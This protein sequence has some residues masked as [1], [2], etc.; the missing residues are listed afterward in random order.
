MVYNYHTHTHRCGH[1]DG[2]E[3]DYIKT[4][5][6]GGIK[7]MGFS[8]HIPLKFKDGTESAYRVPTSEGKEYCD[9]IKAFREKYKGKIDI[10]VGFE[11]EY[12]PELFDE[13]LQSA[14]EYGAEYLI[15]GQHFLAPE[16]T[17]VSANV[18]MTEDVGALKKYVSYVISAMDKNVF[19]YIAHPDFFNFG[20]DVGIYQE[21]M[22]KLCIAA[23][24]RNV[25]LEMNFLGIRDNRHYPNPYF[26]QVAGE[27]KSPVIFGLDAHT[28]ESAFDGDSLVKAKEMV[29]KYDLNYV[30]APKLLPIKH[31]KK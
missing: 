7:Y 19:S 25:P 9:V 22:R 15:L 11:A 30:G 2:V 8:D 1:A 10:M 21:E 28:A 31:L 5:I 4:A 6:A 13:M 16:N 26:W 17:G 29:E 24:E 18:I 20:G 12:Y 3:E 27:E 14:I 23:R